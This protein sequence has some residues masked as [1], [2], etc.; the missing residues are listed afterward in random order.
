MK[1]EF[2]TQ[3]SGGLD[4]HSFIYITKG[5]FVKA[6][7][8]NK[9]KAFKDLNGII[10]MFTSPACFNTEVNSIAFEKLYEHLQKSKYKGLALTYQE[11]NHG[12]TTMQIALVHR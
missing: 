7:E 11:N 4:E 12:N 3:N 2:V 10:E 9:N 6:Y 1:I 5:E 8:I